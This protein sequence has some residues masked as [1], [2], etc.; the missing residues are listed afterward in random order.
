M[1]TV[2]IIHCFIH[3]Q[4]A[5][6]G[7]PALASASSNCRSMC[8][9]AAMAPFKDAISSEGGGGGGDE[10]GGGGGGPEGGGPEGGLLPASMVF[11][12]CRSLRVMTSFLMAFKCSSGPEYHSW[13]S[14]REDSRALTSGVMGAGGGPEPNQRANSVMSTVPSPAT[15][16]GRPIP[17]Y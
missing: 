13:Y 7:A 14:S 1:Q 16:V 3:L 15:P 2:R 9:P 17:P 12:R 4:K 5:G 10:G 6:R 8:C 11:L